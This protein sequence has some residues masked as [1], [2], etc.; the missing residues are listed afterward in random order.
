MQ[1]NV[2]T[3]NAVFSVRKYDIPT[4]I[5]LSDTLQ[6]VAADLN[7]E[8]SKLEVPAEVK[9][10]KASPFAQS[11]NGTW[12]VADAGFRAFIAVSLAA[13]LVQLAIWGAASLSKPPKKGAKG[14]KAAPPTAAKG[15][16]AAKAPASATKRQKT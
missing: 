13:Q 8:G 5:K 3:C 10:A 2:L 1:L 12:L 14:A 4:A 15:K 7:A 6:K 9:K 11:W 16:R